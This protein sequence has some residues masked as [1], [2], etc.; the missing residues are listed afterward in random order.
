MLKKEKVEKVIVELL[1][2]AERHNKKSKTVVSR[3]MAGY[4]KGLEDA[5]EIAATVLE[6]AILVGDVKGE[7]VGELID[8]IARTGTIGGDEGVTTAYSQGQCEGRSDGADY[9]IRMIRTA[10]EETK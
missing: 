5:A 6:T 7:H 2:V 3:T 8:S 9:A 10:W 4:H 1:K